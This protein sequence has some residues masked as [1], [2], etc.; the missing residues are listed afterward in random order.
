MKKII[1]I[2]AI[3]TGSGILSLTYAK[4]VDFSRCKKVTFSVT[5]YYSPLPTQKFFVKGDFVKEITLNGRGIVGASGKR[6]FNGMIA[7]P[8]KYK[9]WTK[10]YLPGLGRWEVADRGGAI[11]AAGQR[12]QK[13][14]R[15]DLWF[16]KWEKALVKAISFGK[17]KMIGYVCPQDKKVKLG[18]DLS[19]IKIYDKFFEKT[20]WMVPLYK[21]RKDPWVK[22][23]QHHLVNLG[24]LSK[25]DITGYFGP[26]TKKAVCEFQQDYKVVSAG[27]PRCGYFWPKTRGALKLALL[28]KWEPLIPNLKISESMPL[29]AFAWNVSVLTNMEF[30]FKKPLKKWEKGKEVEVLQKLLKK[31]GFWEREINGKFDSYTIDALFEFQKKYGILDENASY[32]LRGY[33]WPATREKLNQRLKYWREKYLQDKE[34][35]QKIADTNFDKPYRL[36]QKAEKIKALQAGLKLMG[37]YQGP[38]NGKYTQTT[39]DAVFKFQL[40]TGIL[41]AS[42]PAY[43][44]WYFGPQTRK[45]F[46]KVLKKVVQSKMPKFDLF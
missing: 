3:S 11:V 29:V 39:M 35:L 10:I 14:D 22:I 37:Y 26:K 28:T 7:A 32:T 4:K 5:A 15:L 19:K 21:G 27:S 23:L 8:N 17:K 18:F 13:Y 1:T 42:S 43:L 40:D 41:D 20:F 31:E 38:I 36:N 45:E 25:N 33:M 2:L 46:S 9:F 12:G 34:K 6:V 16:G 44:H 30:A 24:Y